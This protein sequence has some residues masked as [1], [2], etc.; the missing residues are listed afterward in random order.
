MI[1][2]AF[3]IILLSVVILLILLLKIIYKSKI[4]IMIFNIIFSCIGVIVLL[5]CYKYVMEKKSSATIIKELEK[6]NIR[7]FLIMSNRIYQF[8][9]GDIPNQ[10]ILPEEIVG[11]KGI[12]NGLTISNNPNRMAFVFDNSD[13]TNRIYEIWLSNKK[14]MIFSSKYR[15][16][17]LSWSVNRRFIAYWSS[18]GGDNEAQINLCIYDTENKKVIT[19]KQD[20]GYPFYDLDAIPPSWSPDNQHLVF[21]N[22]NGWVDIV[23]INT[24]KTKKLVLGNMPSWSPDGRV[25]AYRE[26]GRKKIS[27][28]ITDEKTRYYYIFPDG[29]NQQFIF[30]SNNTSDILFSGYHKNL[31]WTPDSKFLLFVN[32]YESFSGSFMSKFY[33]F[34]IMNKKLTSISEKFD[35]FVDCFVCGQ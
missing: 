33:V 8:I 17:G 9:A 22:K 24:G 26:S 28:S 14:E 21:A 5:V 18:Q 29:T 1:S 32:Y 31:V 2:Y 27:Q 16:G 3:L 35:G 7:I 20:C 34:N 6:N 11:R 30:D 15:L 25:I 4:N 19:L 12:I 13:L 23:N 10:Q